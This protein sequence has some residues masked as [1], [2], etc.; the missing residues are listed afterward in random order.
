MAPILLIFLPQYL[1]TVFPCRFFNHVALLKV[2]DWCNRFWWSGPVYLVI[3]QL[4]KTAKP[5][6]NVF[7][8][9]PLGVK[10]I[11]KGRGMLPLQILPQP[12]QREKKITFRLK[13]QACEANANGASTTASEGQSGSRCVTYHTCTC[14][15]RTR[16]RQYYV[17]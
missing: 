3:W 1:S 16:M 6:A 2:I 9:H 12:C 10:R 8:W 5:C 14:V 4:G 7:Q 11:F 13:T 17:F 15:Y